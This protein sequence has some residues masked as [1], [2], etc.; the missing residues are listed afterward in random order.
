MASKE[1]RLSE[2]DL[3]HLSDAEL[4]RH[5]SDLLGPVLAPRAVEARERAKHVLGT[6]RG[7]GDNAVKVM[8]P[9]PPATGDVVAS[10]CSIPVV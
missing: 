8:I 5:I 9:V 10:W 7:G 1:I 6:P 2:Q 4:G 3:K